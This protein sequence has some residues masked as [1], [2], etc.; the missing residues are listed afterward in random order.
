MSNECIQINEKTDVIDDCLFTRCD[1]VNQSSYTTEHANQVC[2]IDVISNY[3][4]LVDV[5]TDTVGSEADIS[6]IA[7]ESK[8]LLLTR[9]LLA[10]EQASDDSLAECRAL[11]N[12]GK[13]GYEW[14]DGLLYHIEQIH[15]YEVVQLVIPMCKREYLLQLA[16][17]QCGFHQGQ[18]RT[19]ERIRLSGLYFPGIKEAVHTFCNQVGLALK[20]VEFVKLIE[21]QSH[22]F[23]EQK[24]L[25]NIFSWML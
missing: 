2:S 11:A 13:G 6:T 15:G 24:F 9:E 7:N 23:L 3:D 10:K 20:S 25:A 16:H 18:K 22:L 8:T 5:A 17:I 14:R 1:E 4:A 19:L 12:A 21:F